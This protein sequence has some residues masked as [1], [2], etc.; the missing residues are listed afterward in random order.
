[1]SR[2][3]DQV[4]EK[5]QGRAKVGFKK[6]GQTMER[7]DFNFLDWLTYLQEELM[8][9]IVYL[10]RIIEEEKGRKADQI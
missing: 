3:E 4:C 2:I 1:M 9:G 10:E 5:I 7:T 8:D 6:Y